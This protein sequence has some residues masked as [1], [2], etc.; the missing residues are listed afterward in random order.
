MNRNKGGRAAASSARSCGAVR[1]FNG[2]RCVLPALSRHG[3]DANRSRVEGKRETMKRQLLMMASTLMLALLFTTTTFASEITVRGRL[4]KTVEAGGWL[5][6]TDAEKYL[7]L[8]P[9]QF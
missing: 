4:G 9:Q 8:N 7:I 2:A 1:S 6:L 5:I 3:L